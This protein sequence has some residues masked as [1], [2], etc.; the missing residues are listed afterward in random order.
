MNI[1]DL[2]NRR[3][4]SGLSRRKL[5]KIIGYSVIW[6]TMFE[7]EG[8]RRVSKDFIEKY[9]NTVKRYEKMLKG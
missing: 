9:R 2:I 7:N 6:I 8:E 4:K 1:D 3:K 5:S